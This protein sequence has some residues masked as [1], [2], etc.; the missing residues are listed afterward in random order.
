MK[1]A[2]KIMALSIF[3]VAINASA[4]SKLLKTFKLNSCGGNLE[5]RE[6]ANSN[7]AIVF[8]KNNDGVNK[9][10]QL[11]FIDVNKAEIISSYQLS[12]GWAYT[13]S[14]TQTAILKGEGFLAIKILGQNERHELLFLYTDKNNLINSELF[15]Y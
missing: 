3:F 14:S 11:Q 7:L 9:C 4:K 8:K 15:P 10:D 6:A 2:F 5:L 12:K 1:F 13:L